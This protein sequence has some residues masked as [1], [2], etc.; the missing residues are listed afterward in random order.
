MHKPILFL[1]LATA[2]L[3]SLAFA[4]PIYRCTVAGGATV[5]SQTPCGTDAKQVGASGAA[6]TVGTPQMDAHNDKN[7][8]AQIEDRCE[9]QSRATLDSYSTRFAQANAEIATLH[10]NLMV[11]GKTAAGADKDAQVQAKISALEVLKTDLLSSQDRQIS[12]QRRQCQMDRD[13]ELKRQA[14]R[15]AQRSVAKR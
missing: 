6:K 8:L 7:A 11:P 14:D 4:A 9:A 5:F 15:D 10:K 12:A 13:T 2:G 3:P 1:L